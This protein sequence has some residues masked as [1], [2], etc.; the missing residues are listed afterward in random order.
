MAAVSHLLLCIKSDR[1]I[2]DL[3]GS[4]RSGVFICQAQVMTVLI[5]I[6]QFTLQV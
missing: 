1:V 4:K 6:G 2:S 5:L 3:S